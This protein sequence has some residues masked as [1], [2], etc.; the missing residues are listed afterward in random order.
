M[1]SCV[2]KDKILDKQKEEVERAQEADK[3]KSR[4]VIED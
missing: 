3:S 2:D 1:R 4:C